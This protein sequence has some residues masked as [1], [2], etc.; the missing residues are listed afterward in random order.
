M[1]VVQG[2]CVRLG[3][4]LLDITGSCREK[5]KEATMGGRKRLGGREEE[6]RREDVRQKMM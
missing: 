6:Q 1:E 4:E 5:A 2:F 3:K